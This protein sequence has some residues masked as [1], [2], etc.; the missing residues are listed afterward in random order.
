MDDHSALRRGAAPGPGFRR[1][2]PLPAR[3]DPSQPLASARIER[4]LALTMVCGALA[5]PACADDIAPPL[6]PDAGLAD[7]T[8]KVATVRSSDGT[9]G[10]RVDATSQTDWILVDLETGGQVAA[11]A[12]WDLGFQRFHLKLNGGASG[13]R[14]VEIAPLP[15]ADFAALTEAPASGW[16]RDVADGDDPGTDPDYA[17]E[18]GEGWYAYDVETHALTPRPVVWV[19]ATSEGRRLKVVI[20]SYYDDAGTSGH[21]RLRWAPL[22]GA[23]P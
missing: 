23:R 7:A 1:A 15:G 20:E 16:I 13:D 12:P 5:V 14:G 4:V 8:D 2:H 10:T 3:R 17:F 6:E 22:E 18:Q 21:L 9:Y 11:D 19:V